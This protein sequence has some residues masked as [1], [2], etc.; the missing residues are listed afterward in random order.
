MRLNGEGQLELEDSSD[1]FYALGAT[2]RYMKMIDVVT[3]NKFAL[4]LLS[5]H[6]QL[7][8]CRLIEDTHPHLMTLPRSESLLLVG[9]V[10]NDARENPDGQA[11]ALM[12][13]IQTSLALHSHTAV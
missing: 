4:D 8:A 2:L 5:L 12:E 7:E 10:S 1:V 13:G 11:A 9:L 6:E 3:D